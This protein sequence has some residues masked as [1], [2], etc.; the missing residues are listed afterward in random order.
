MFKSKRSES[1]AAKIKQVE[2]CELLLCTLKNNAI[3]GLR[4]FSDEKMFTVNA[5]IN[6]RNDTGLA[7]DP[8][9]VSIVAKPKFPANVHLLGVILI[10][11][12]HDA[13]L[14]EIWVYLKENLFVLTTKTLGVQW[15]PM[16]YFQTLNQ[17]FVLN[18]YTNSKNAQVIFSCRRS[19]S[20]N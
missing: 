8:E 4:F 18:L 9:D 13:Q 7:H 3:R 20:L 12:F 19:A 14:E 10:L 16:I 11:N 2:R 17:R 6:R 5:K 15:R 1:E